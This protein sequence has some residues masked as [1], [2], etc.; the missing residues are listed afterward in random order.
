MLYKK[1]EKAWNELSET[2][3]SEF[4]KRVPSLVSLS[5]IHIEKDKETL[6]RVVVVF[7]NFTNAVEKSSDIANLKAV[8]RD[9]LKQIGMVRIKRSGAETLILELS[10]VEISNLDEAVVKV[11]TRKDNKLVPAMKCLGGPKNGQRTQDV[12]TC[13]EPPSY[14]RRTARKVSSRKN[15]GAIA[16]KRQKTKLTNII[17]RKRLKKANDRLKKARGGKF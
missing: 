6:D 14:A 2:Q 5:S 8:I 16:K 9:W 17:G 4:K 13:M 1:I 3:A 15:K 12:A 7:S 10:N 11:F